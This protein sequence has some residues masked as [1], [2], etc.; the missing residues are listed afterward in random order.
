MSHH[1]ALSRQCCISFFV[2]LLPTCPL[3]SSRRL[4]TAP[5]RPTSDVPRH[6]YPVGNASSSRSL[7]R[8]PPLPRSSLSPSPSPYFVPTSKLNP[9]PQQRVFRDRTSGNNATLYE[10]LPSERAFSRV[11]TGPYSYRPHSPSLPTVRSRDHCWRRE[12]SVT[13]ADDVHHA[14]AETAHTA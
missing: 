10:V 12:R 2:A 6:G 4:R 13:A 5:N 7:S 1:A 14:D 3:P 11:L 9:P 8:P